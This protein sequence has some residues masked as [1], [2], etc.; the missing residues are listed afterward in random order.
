VNFAAGSITLVQ[1]IHAFGSTTALSSVPN[2]SS[3]GQAVT[4]TATVATVPQSSTIP[5]GMVT[6][7]EGSSILAQAALGSGGTASFTMPSLSAGSHNIT[8]VYAS[9]SLSAASSGSGTQSVQSGGSTTTAVSSS[10][11][12]S[13]FGQAVTI[14]AAVRSAAG[15]PT[16]TVTFKDGSTILATRT[17]D[18]TGHSTF[19]TS[20]LAVGSHSITA[21]YGGDANFL[22]SASPVLNQTVNPDGSTTAIASS[23]DPAIIG[24]AVTF[25]ATVSANAPGSGTPAGTVTFRDKNANLGTVSLDG[26]GHASF[27]IS[28]LSQGAHQITTV[29]NGSTSFAVS[30]SSTLVQNISKK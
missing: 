17:V 2:P 22:G 20:T 18:P 26:T 14:T 28:T 11:N 5:T 7:Q 9:D 25:T 29:Y 23:S 21:A 10:T 19:T 13:V 4:F 30:T 3:P 12:P 1:N 8:A 15:T 6:F 27:T 24:Q 16:G